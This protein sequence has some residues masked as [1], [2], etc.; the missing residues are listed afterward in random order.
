MELKV[1]GRRNTDPDPDDVARAIAVRPRG[2][3]WAIRLQSSGD[4]FIE[5]VPDTGRSWRVVLVERGRRFNA[6]RPM[7]SE[8]LESM[9]V[10][11]L[12]DNDDWRDACRFVPDNAERARSRPGDRNS[13]RLPRWAVVAVAVTLA[14]IGGWVVFNVLEF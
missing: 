1:G 6:T 14:A 13:S 2:A 9:L 5:A 8:A 10:N 11:Y 7:G 4:H 3:D 12:H